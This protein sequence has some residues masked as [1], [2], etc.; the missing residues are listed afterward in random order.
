MKL[1]P[2][3]ATGSEAE[4]HQNESNGLSLAQS[5]RTRPLWLVSIIALLYALSSGVIV[6]HVVSSAIELGNPPAGSAAILSIMGVFAMLGYLVLGS[7]ADRLGNYRVLLIGFILMTVATM[8]LVVARELW[9]FYLFAAIFGFGT[10]GWTVMAP[11]IAGLFGMKAHGELIG[12]I[13]FISSL[14]AVI[15]P[16][17]A[18]Q[19]FDQSQSYFYAW[20]LVFGVCF[21]CAAAVWLLR[22]AGKPIRPP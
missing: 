2:Y 3:G 14:G 18:G 21:I 17:A 20:L 12:F 9:T 10:G 8:P 6:V 19:I 16:I 11:L 7:T 1:L 13:Y 22:L 4:N 5:L 15:G